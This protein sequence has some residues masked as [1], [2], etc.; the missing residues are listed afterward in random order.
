MGQVSDVSFP[1]ALVLFKFLKAPNEAGSV[2][3]RVALWPD[4]FGDAKRVFLLRNTSNIG[5]PKK[6]LFTVTHEHDNRKWAL[7][8]F[9]LNALDPKFHKVTSY[10][11]NFQNFT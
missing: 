2:L 11:W 5:E 6:T 8:P 1:D 10:A 3:C 4:C 7:F 9:S